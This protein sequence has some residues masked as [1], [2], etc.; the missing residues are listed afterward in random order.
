M[1]HSL[2]EIAAESSRREEIIMDP[3]IPVLIWL[4]GAV[5]CSYIA[6]LR[7]VKSTLFRNLIV[8]LLG[9]L[10]IPLVFLAKSERKVSTQ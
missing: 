8:V 6:K 1:L 7:G 2:V 5:I 10:A 3:Y 4:V 9:P